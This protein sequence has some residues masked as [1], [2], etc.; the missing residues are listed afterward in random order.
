MRHAIKEKNAKNAVLQMF[1]FD[2]I[3]VVELE[4][5]MVGSCTKKTTI[6]STAHVVFY[7]TLVDGV[8]GVEV[9]D[10]VAGS[11]TKKTMVRAAGSATVSTEGSP[12]QEAAGPWA[13]A[14][15]RAIAGAAFTGVF[16]GLVT[17]GA[18]VAGALAEPEIGE[19][20]GVGNRSPAK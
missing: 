11:D 17:A 14:G 10:A 9:E 3:V 1:S 20:A 12:E 4:S 15:P 18:N 6:M 16:V 2:E 13:I 19:V 7:K 5:A 8:M